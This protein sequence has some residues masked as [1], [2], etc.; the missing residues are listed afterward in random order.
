MPDMITLEQNQIHTI[1]LQKGYQWLPL[2]KNAG[3]RN[4]IHLSLQDI[5]TGF[6]YRT[7][8]E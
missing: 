7:D 8:N 6:R 5:C 3:N 4:H 2:R 1:L